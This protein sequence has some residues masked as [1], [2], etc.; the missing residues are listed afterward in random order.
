[1]NDNLFASIMDAIEKT[2]PVIERIGLEVWNEAELSQVE[3]KS[4]QIHIRELEAAGF[5]LISM[6][7]CGYQ[8]AFI[9]EW[10]QGEGGAKV[11]FLP[12]YDA[13]P[14]L[15]NEAVTEQKPRGNG[16]TNGHGCGHNQIGAACT[17]AAITLK[18]LMEKDSIAGTIR[19]YGC[20]AEEK[21]GVKPQMARDGFFNDLDGAL[22][23]HPAPFAIAGHVRTA[24]VNHIEI[25]FFG[26]TAHA[27]VSPW[28]GRSALHAAELFAHG[29]NLMREHVEPTTRIQYIIQSGGLATNV[30]TD[31]ATIRLATRD[32]DRKRVEAVTEWARQVAEGAAMATQTRAEFRVLFGLYDLLPN[33]PLIE[34][35][36][37]NM[38]RVGLPKWTEEEQAFARA[39]QKGMNVP[40]K[41]MATN[42]I[43][44]PT[45]KTVGGGTDVGDVSWV[46]PT[47]AFGFPT[48]PLGVS[49]HTWAATACGGMSIGVKGGI[50]AAAI[51]AATG[52][53]LMTDTKLREAARADFEKRTAGRTYVC[54]IPA[55]QV[56]PSSM[57]NSE[58]KVG[59]DEMLYHPDSEAD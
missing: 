24:A 1:M 10:S 23:F 39:C 37:A 53:E 33:G 57:A 12:E 48:L 4:A 18:K 45:E 17:G 9:A 58:S 16:N 28:E 43:L 50:A 56:G 49:L 38:Q 44:V 51:M 20:A 32:Q 22:A 55:S 3:L 54:A 5:K 59:S 31:Y 6:G 30:V 29:L 42:V 26:K 7:T 41:G 19:V 34:S 2:K 8:A 46:T 11:G 14:G 15:G 27:G 52:Y 13:L 47:C 25:E 40:E 36:H 21:E 35:L